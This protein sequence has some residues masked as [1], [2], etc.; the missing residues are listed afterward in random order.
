MCHVQL[1]IPSEQALQKAEILCLEA[2]GPLISSCL[3]PGAFTS[4]PPNR[5]LITAKLLGKLGL[6]EYR[7]ILFVF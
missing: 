2:Q 1:Q 7:G 4:T 6:P 3:V 5:L